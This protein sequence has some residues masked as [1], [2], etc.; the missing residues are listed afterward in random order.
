[1]LHDI[2]IYRFLLAVFSLHLPYEGR[3]ERT[4]RK[5]W[6]PKSLSTSSGVSLPSLPPEESQRL[7][8]HER[9]FC[10]RPCI[11]VQFTI[12]PLDI[13][14]CRYL[15][16][17]TGVSKRVNSTSS[18]SPRISLIVNHDAQRVQM[19]GIGIGNQRVF[20]SGALSTTSSNAGCG[21]HTPT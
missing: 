17:A 4:V 11:L 5:R 15:Q 10:L 13:P 19:I 20:S 1:M 14:T 12:L 3:P 9:M 21:G 2:L 6:L 8:L 7:I 16:Q 18:L